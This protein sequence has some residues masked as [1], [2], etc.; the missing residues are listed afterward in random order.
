M[1][2]RILI[3]ALCLSLLVGCTPT[4]SVAEEPI[5][6][7]IW[8]YYGGTAQQT[9]DYLVQNFN[10]TVG[11]EENIVVESYAYDGVSQLAEA[12]ERS[13]SGVA[14]S[15]AMPSIFASY[16][17]SLIP[18]IAED[19]IANLDTN[20]TADELE[21]YYTPFVEEGRLGDSGELMILPIAKSTEVLHIN[22]TAFDAFAQD[23]GYSYEDLSTWEGIAQISEAYY[24]WTD[25]QTETPD[26]GAAF[27]GT[28]SMANFMI[29]GTKQLGQDIFT[30]EDTQV[31]QNLTQDIAQRIW[32]VF[33]IPFLQGHYSANA[34]Y[35]S[36]DVTYGDIVAYMGSTASSYYFPSQ[37]LS[38]SGEYVDIECL[39]MPCPVFEGGD[40]VA[41]Q[42]GAG[43]AVSK[44][45]PEEEEAAACFLKW[46]TQPA[47]NCGFAVSTG[48][49]PVVNASLDLD[50]ILNE[51]ARDGSIDKSLP[52]VQ[53]TYSTYQQLENYELYTSTPFDG[54]DDARTI[55]ETSLPAYIA[56][57]QVAY[58]ALLLSGNTPESVLDTFTGETNFLTWYAEITQ[59][60]EA[61]IQG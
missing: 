28:D 42:Q 46:F 43:M 40:T 16:A 2:K 38:S 33:Y 34:S 50:I 10:R 20:F 24:N 19:K 45:T 32:D 5:T 13:A 6:L 17:D 51:M 57:D 12:V 26:D 55:L 4:A 39:T 25:A 59:A 15:A 8:H 49:M 41:V 7:T 23:T 31:S 18:L 56:Q 52:I 53:A 47:N 58:Q 21:S 3:I 48:Y 1:K 54:S 36:D 22:Q 37:V 35:R 9:F 11:A 14:G 29:I 61:A 30:V 60:L 27:F 44:S